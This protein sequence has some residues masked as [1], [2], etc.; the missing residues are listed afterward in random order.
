MN[1]FEK[2]GKVLCTS[3]IYEEVDFGLI[4]LIVSSV[5]NQS[6]D[7]DYLQVI[8][9]EEKEDKTILHI[10]QEETET[11]KK[12]DTQIELRKGM[13]HIPSEKIYFIED[14]YPNDKRVQTLLFSS[15]Y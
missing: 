11:V 5:F 13:F 12:Q 7:K 9:F 15:E 4:N 3:G 1:Y 10:K 2:R 14:I 6:Y 8:T